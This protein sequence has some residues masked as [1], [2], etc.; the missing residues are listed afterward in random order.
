VVN[1]FQCEECERHKKKPTKALKIIECPGC[2]VPTQKSGGCNHMEC[3]CGKH[4]CFA[5]GKA[6]PQDEIYAH[7]SSAHGGYYYTDGIDDDDDDEEEEEYD[8][9]DDD[10]E[11]EENDGED[12]VVHVRR[13]RRVE[14]AV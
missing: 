3:V 14:V 7:M 1:D 4:W 9:I 5:C 8:G 13:A 6:F 2:G 12:E 10:E 11:E